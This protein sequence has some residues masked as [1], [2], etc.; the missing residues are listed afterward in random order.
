M[1]NKNEDFEQDYYS[2]TAK[3]NYKIG[4]TGVRLMKW[5]APC[6]HYHQKI[7]YSDLMASIL[8]YLNG[9]S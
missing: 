8:K 6:D 2:G 4:H 1:K 7:K 5:V 3:G 9:I